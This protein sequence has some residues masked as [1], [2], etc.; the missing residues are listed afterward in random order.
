MSDEEFLARW[1][2]RK[3]EAKA[4]VDAPPLTEPAEVEFPSLAVVGALPVIRQA[5]VPQHD[6]GP[7]I[8]WVQGDD[9]AGGAGRHRE[10]V[11]PAPGEHQAARRVDLDELTG[12]LD[13]VAHDHAVAAARYRLQ[14]RVGAHPLDVTAGVGEVGEHRLRLFFNLRVRGVP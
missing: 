5:V 2:R 3:R 1:S 13:T 8:F 7:A 4:A 10:V 12:R 11:G 6:P 9:D 14:P